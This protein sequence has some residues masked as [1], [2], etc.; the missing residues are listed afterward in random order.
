M[1]TKSWGRGLLAMLGL[2]LLTGPSEGAVGSCSDKT[3]PLAGPADAAAY[4]DEREQL[5]CLRRYERGEL[6][7][8]EREDCRRKAVAVC[9]TR[10]F[11]PGCAP[12]ERQVRACLDALHSRSTLDRNVGEIKECNSLCELDSAA[13]LD[14]GAP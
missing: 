5:L 11:F 10:E 3:D 7:F 13:Q 14:G 12:T 2:A 6:N 9:Q 4:C 1:T 8:P